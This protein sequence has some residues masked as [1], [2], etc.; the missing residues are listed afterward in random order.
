MVFGAFHLSNRIASIK[1][2]GENSFRT[3]QVFLD[4][5]H[6]VHAK[7]TDKAEC[8]ARMLTDFN[9][10]FIQAST[11]KLENLR[12][13]HA[14]SK[15]ILN[16]FRCGHVSFSLYF[17]LY[18]TNDVIRFIVKTVY[19]GITTEKNCICINNNAYTSIKLKSSNIQ[20]FRS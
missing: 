9:G 3:T 14:S 19:E 12:E 17:I 20:T 1:I 2:L 8:P 11:F 6:C 10:N 18:K 7:L 4:W 16:Y 5:Q 15:P 13:F